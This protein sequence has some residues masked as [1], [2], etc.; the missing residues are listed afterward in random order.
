MTLCIYSNLY[1]VSCC[2]SG[3]T[4]LL[5]FY[6]YCSYIQ[7]LPSDLLNALDLEHIFS[8][9]PIGSISQAPTVQILY[10]SSCTEKHHTISTVARML[11]GN[12][13]QSACQHLKSDVNTNTRYN[14]YKANHQELDVHSKDCDFFS[15][16]EID[17]YAH[18]LR[19]IHST[20]N[21]SYHHKFASAVDVP[22]QE[23]R[24]VAKK[25]VN[26]TLHIACKTIESLDRRSSIEYLIASTKRPKVARSPSPPP[27]LFDI[28]EEREDNQI[29]PH[30]FEIP[31]VLIG[32]VERS[33]TPEVHK[34]KK[35]G[36]KRKR[37]KSHDV[38]MQDTDNYEKKLSIEKET[39]DKH[40]M[41]EENRK[42][43]NPHQKTFSTRGVNE[44]RLTSRMKRL[45]IEADSEPGVDEN[46]TILSSVTIKESD[47]LVDVSREHEQTHTH[48]HSL[49]QDCETKT[50]PSDYPGLGILSSLNSDDD[51]HKSLKSDTPELP[52]VN[53]NGSTAV[54]SCDMHDLDL[55][56]IIHS[57]PH[58][59]PCQKFLCN[60]Q[61]EV[62]LVYH[63]WVYKDSP[64]DPAITLTSKVDMGI[65]EPC[66]V[67]PVH[68][69]L[70]DSGIPFLFLDERYVFHSTTL[71]KIL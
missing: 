70:H 11:I 30:S 4:F 43:H 14:G 27:S 22:D 66:L 21:M 36:L 7:K 19:S 25:L 59:S 10:T 40:L 20:K 6:Q 48:G 3:H 35:L 41:S 68:L 53:L 12:V 52:P 8:S 38:A 47:E 61:D 64:F 46:Y 45:S 37:S 34:N 18:T 33:E 57:C 62:N 2:K 49:L 16:Q 28:T 26:K 31:Q 9:R 50:F 5:I 23:I 60:N 56:I 69:E 63:C 29:T 17:S 58:P 39:A 55:F 65:F 32:K 54:T 71:Q 13:L 15:T 42:L 67:Q 51:A 1:Q 44:N 24:I